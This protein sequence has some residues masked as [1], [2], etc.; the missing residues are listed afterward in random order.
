MRQAHAEAH[1]AAHGS[2]G[3]VVVDLPKVGYL[4]FWMGSRWGRLLMVVLPLLLL[5]AYE[6][7][8][9]VRAPAGEPRPRR[10]RHARR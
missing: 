3:R 4:L 7:R 6:L 9:I 10:A 1:H 2:I 8:S 5:G